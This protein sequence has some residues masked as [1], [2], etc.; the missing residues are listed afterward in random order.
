MGSQSDPKMFIFFPKEKKKTFKQ[1]YKGLQSR[2]KEKHKRRGGNGKMEKV[3]PGYPLYIH[4]Y[5]LH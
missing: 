4:V 5:V 3:N 2:E 1:T